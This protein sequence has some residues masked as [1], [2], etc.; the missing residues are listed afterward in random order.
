MRGDPK[1]KRRAVKQFNVAM[2]DSLRGLLMDRFKYL[3]VSFK[4]NKKRSSNIIHRVG[5]TIG[6]VC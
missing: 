3:R 6:A 5:G 4:K 2:F 1:A